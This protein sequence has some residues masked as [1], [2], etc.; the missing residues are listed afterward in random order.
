[1]QNH[2]FVER[3]IRIFCR[4]T[5]VREITL[6]REI[7]KT[8]CGPMEVIV[9]PRPIIEPFTLSVTF[10]PSHKGKRALGGMMMLLVRECRKKRV[11]GKRRGR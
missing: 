3:F 10:I 2:E 1:M 9:E 6:E 7:P 5:K 4:G 11:P 8:D